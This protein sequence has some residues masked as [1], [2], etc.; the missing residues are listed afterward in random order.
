M[1]FYRI[2]SFSMMSQY[3]YI[4]TSR[5]V[6]L[7]ENVGILRVLP[8]EKIKTLVLVVYIFKDYNLQ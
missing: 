1:P 5:H 4:Q 6:P 2:T 3:S 8:L 7:K